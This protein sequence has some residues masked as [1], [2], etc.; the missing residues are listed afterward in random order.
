MTEVMARD[1]VGDDEGHP[2]VLGA[3]LQ[4][5]PLDVEIVARYRERVRLPQLRHLDDV[6]LGFGTAR[7]KPLRNPRTRSAAQPWDSTTAT[8]NLSSTSKL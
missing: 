3:A 5:L 8:V 2:L 4:Q 7:L 6:P 1:L